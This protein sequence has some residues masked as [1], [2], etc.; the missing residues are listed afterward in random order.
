MTNINLRPAKDLFMTVFLPQNL[1]SVCP[2]TKQTVWRI[3]PTSRGFFLAWVLTFTKSLAWVVSRV[4]LCSEQVTLTW[5]V[6]NQLHPTD[7][8]PEGFYYKCN[9]K[10]HDRKT[11]LLAV[12][13]KCVISFQL[14]GMIICKENLAFCT[15]QV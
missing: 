6:Y 12:S 14:P 13:C 15:P 11:P 8:P 9:A 2:Y 5:R 1:T 10:S 4:V 7:K 3:L